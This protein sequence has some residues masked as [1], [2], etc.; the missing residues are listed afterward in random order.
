MATNTFNN[1]VKITKMAMDCLENNLTMAKHVNREYRSEFR[2]TGAKMGDTINVRIPGFYGVRHGSAADP[3]GYNDTFVP[4]TLNQHGVDLQFTTKQLLLNM[5]EGGAFQQNVM[6]PLIAPLANYIDAQLTGLYTGINQA[7]G[8]IGTSPTDLSGYL[9]AGAILDDSA[10]PRDGQRNAILS[11]WSQSTLVNGLKGLFHSSTEISRQ[12]T[13]GNMGLAAGLK[14][15][16]DQNINRHKVGTI[17]T[18][19]P[20]IDTAPADGSTT[21]DTKG[22]ASGAATLNK[23]DIITIENVYKVNPVSKQV[24]TQL[25]QFVVTADTTSVGV[26]MGT[27]PVFPALVLTGPLQ[28]IN[29]L[30]VANAKIYVWGTNDAAASAKSGP[31]DMVFHKDA[32]G[33][34]SVDLPKPES[35]VFCQ[36]IRSEKLDI[37][38]RLIQYYN[39]MTDQELYR[40]DVL[41]GTAILRPT[42]AARVQG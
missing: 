7:A 3:Q 27:L 20:L 36:R 42:F 13:E 4:V 29:A 5:E 11:P 25:M 28:N 16:M 26:D 9:N 34:I 38:M 23:G 15:S 18:S 12:Y 41:F 30:P 19:T 33:L 32:F 2:D 35:A 10:V 14:F 37:S 21:L 8:T 31:T 6:N 24:T 17:G 40:V 39:G 22:W 1:A